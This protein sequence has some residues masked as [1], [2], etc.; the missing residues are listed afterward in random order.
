MAPTAFSPI[1]LETPD[2][3]EWLHYKSSSFTVTACLHLGRNMH[4]YAGPVVLAVYSRM[5]NLQPALEQK[6][7]PSMLRVSFLHAS[8]SYVIS[9]PSLLTGLLDY[10]ARDGFDAHGEDNN[11]I[12]LSG[13]KDFTATSKERG[14]RGV[15]F[16]FVKMPP[17]AIDTDADVEATA[18]A[19]LKNVGLNLNH[20]QRRLDKYGLATYEYTIRFDM[21]PRFDPVLLRQLRVEAPRTP[22]LNT[23]LHITISGEFA[24]ELAICRKCHLKRCI[25]S[26]PKPLS[27]QSSRANHANAFARLLKKQRTE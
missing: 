16:G 2:Q 9:Y 12:T 11:T 1:D 14:N 6:L 7:L 21:S 4:Q 20:F 3:A 19:A 17:G 23:P 18:S 13:P 26:A 22:L 5:V 15:T 8:Q 24:D 27:V 10:A 25:C